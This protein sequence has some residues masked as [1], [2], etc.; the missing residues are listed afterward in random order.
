[1]TRFAAT[2]CILAM[3]WSAGQAG[4][5]T[6]PATAI[7]TAKSHKPQPTTGLTI[8]ESDFTEILR[9][10]YK[11]DKYTELL[12]KTARIDFDERD[13]SFC[14]EVLMLQA[15]AYRRV[16]SSPK[17]LRSMRAETP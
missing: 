10:L 4:P 6:Q 5:E 13:F 8:T 7:S 9:N 2:I 16:G 11:T 14:W 12:R 17:R 15:E 3:V 1:M